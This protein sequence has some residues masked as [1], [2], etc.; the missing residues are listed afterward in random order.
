VFVLDRFLPLHGDLL[1][2]LVGF[3]PGFGGG[4]HVDHFGVRAFVVERLI[5][6]V[7][8]TGD[9]HGAYHGECH[10]CC[11]FHNGLLSD[12][13]HA[14]ITGARFNVVGAIFT[15]EAR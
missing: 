1:A 12:S 5:A 10:G 6:A 13:W 14:P 15:R 9:G 7:T 2:T 4:L 11:C 8:D 3:L